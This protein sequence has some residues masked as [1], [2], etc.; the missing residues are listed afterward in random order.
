MDER[1]RQFAGI[2]AA[3][4][5]LYL[6]YTLARSPVIPIFARELGA[7][8][9]QV[10]W[11]VAGSTITGIL[12]KLPAGALSDRFG[13]KIMLFLGSCFFAI[14]PFFYV[15]ATSV[16][17]LFILRVIH[18]NATAVF[19]PS[20]SA[21]ISDITNPSRRG[22]RLGTYSSMQGIGQALGP[23]LGGALISWR[24]FSLP[25]VISGFAGCL[26][27]LCVLMSMR[28]GDQQSTTNIRKS[29]ISGI[30]EA[31]HNRS[32]VST[33]CTVASFML[34]VGAYN[35]FLPLYAKDAIGLDAWHVG[36]VFALQ[37][38]TA[39]V[40]RPLMGRFS[41]RVGRKPLIVAALVWAAILMAFLPG[42]SAFGPLLLFGCAW[43]A[44][45]S[46]VSSVSGALITDLSHKAM[47]GAAHGLFGTI[48]DIGEASGPIAAG[49]LVAHAGYS[50]M[51]VVMSVLLF[52][53]T[54][55]FAWT[56]IHLTPESGSDD[57]VET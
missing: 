37:T 51:F 18:G 29:P 42:V 9:E 33:S 44:G 13:R 17:A 14:T 35:A 36:A 16:T 34:V 2:S 12:V 1:G 56:R 38:S 54:F 11:V 20:A 27:M 30:R 40:A 31:F 43:G 32:I 48:Y 46:V 25:F 57:R 10:G 5:S 45:L 47:Y 39:L 28:T 4:L 41:D 22:I 6:S 55:V 24:G 15:L 21:A 50:T 53:T 19:G 8:P 23:L 26:G 49:L 52:L 7:S 3:G